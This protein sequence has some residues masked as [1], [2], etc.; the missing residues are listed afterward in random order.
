[1]R[2]RAVL[3][4]VL[5][6]M[7]SQSGSAA[8]GEGLWGVYEQ[9]LKGAKYVDLTHTITPKIPVWAGFSPST[10]APAKAGKDIEGYAVK[11]EV[12]TYAKHGFEATE[13][14]LA[15]DQLG[16]QLDPPAHW[17][18]EYPALD[19]LPATYAIRP[20]VVISIVEQLKSNSNYALQVADIEAWET[21][22]GRIPE[23]SVVFVRS[24]WSKAWPDPKLATLKEFPGVGLAALKFLHQERSI[25]FHGH[26]P[27]DTDSTPNLEG[28]Y[29]LMHNGYAQA[30]GVANLDQVPETGALVI[31]GYPKFAGGLGGYARYVAICPPDWPHGI[32][33][34]PGDAPLPKSDKALRYDEAAGMRVR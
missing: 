7:L 30:E 21:R 12:Y 34:G 15:T 4:A 2:S 16:T 33:I 3:A 26:E 19:E 8:A 24:D 25:L 10:F 9:A 13:Y 5:A 11:G 29:W 14:L 20:L 28:E 1:M 32:T 31:I 27:L 18:P 22:H 6:M 23:G 17:A